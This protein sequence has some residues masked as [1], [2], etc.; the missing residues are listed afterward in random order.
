MKRKIEKGA[1]DKNNAATGAAD[2]V[3]TKITPIKKSVQPSAKAG[4]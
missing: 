2:L 4:P 3:T 1:N